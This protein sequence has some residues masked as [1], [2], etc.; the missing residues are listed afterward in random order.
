VSEP[1]SPELV[2]VDPELARAERARLLALEYIETTPPPIEPAQTDQASAAHVRALEAQL[3]A[4]RVHVRE[5]KGEV[6]ALEASHVPQ[7]GSRDIRKRFASA[8]LPI[9]L[10]ANVIFIAVAVAES[11]S[12]EPSSVPPAS[13]ATT[14]PDAGAPSAAGDRTARVRLPSGATAPSKPGRS[15]KRR[16]TRPSSA[17]WHLTSGE[18]ERRVLALVVQ[19]PKGKLPPS[20]IDPR[21]GL[22][23]NG[24]QAQCRLS[25][26][27]R[28][29]R[30]LVR[31]TDHTA[32]EGLHVRY[33]VDY[34][35]RATLTWY[36]YRRG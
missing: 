34:A 15:Q 21:T 14:E 9:S 36:R 30:C 11:R 26:G 6:S 29:F 7:T 24:L 23:K 17:R 16:G 2:L 28:T 20:L 10:I 5:L 35:G 3:A 25:G 32:A 8:I 4:L 27:P 13:I 31:P 1:I 12:V 33:R 18:V 19:S 22:A